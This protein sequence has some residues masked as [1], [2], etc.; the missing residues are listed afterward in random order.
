MIGT[1]SFAVERAGWMLFA[2]F[3]VA[4]V[5]FGGTPSL[6]AQALALGAS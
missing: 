6:P 1:V 4:V 5:A 3:L 2:A